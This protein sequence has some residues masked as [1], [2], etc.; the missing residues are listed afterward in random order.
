[1]KVLVAVHGFP[2]THIAGAERQAERTASWLLRSGYD[3][4]V[5]AI[6]SP[7][8]DDTR[9]ITTTRPDGLT[10]HRLYYNVAK[11]PDPDCALYDSPIVGMA[12]RSVL[13]RGMFDVL[14]V[15]S[16]YLFGIQAVQAAHE[17]GVPVVISPT[18]YWFMCKQLN[19]LRPS[20]RLCSGPET[21]LKCACCALEE[22]RRF[23][24]PALCAP[25]L[26]DTVLHVYVRLPFASNYVDSVKRRQTSLRRCLLEADA[27]IC[28]SQFIMQFYKRFGFPMERCRII[29]FGLAIP[30]HTTTRRSSVLTRPLRLGY[31][32]QVKYH[33]GVDLLINAVLGLLNEGYSI[34]LGIWDTETS[35]TRYGS[36]LRSRSAARDEIQWNSRCD[37][38]GV[39]Q[40]LQE[41]DALVVPS[42]W[43][44]NS[45]T[46]ISEAHAAGV[47]VVCTELGGMAELVRNEEWGLTF[48]HNDAPHL[49]TQLRRLLVERGLLEKLRANLPRVR[50]ID[51]EMADVVD[52]YREV[53]RKHPV[54]LIHC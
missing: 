45:P 40:A 32:G 52:V 2:P 20:G 36:R 48:R 17:Q 5:F 11:H 4:E 43:Y 3:V 24:W 22:K 8:A 29:R 25:T 44:E 21:E 39:W 41:M 7:S 31:L 38:A 13:A 35:V 49:Q 50:S 34:K 46:V 19:L 30:N 10:V 27:L 23:R 15:I 28:N 42:R 16:G 37:T 14:H 33:K 53:L 47:V 12:L 54:Q 18:E 6:E 51:E 26:I 9:L 1:M